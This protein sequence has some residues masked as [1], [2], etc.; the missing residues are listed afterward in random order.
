MDPTQGMSLE[1]TAR[2]RKQAEAVNSRL[3][4]KDGSLKGDMGRDAFL[5]LLVTELRH[6]DPT[7]PMQDREFISQMAQFSSLEQ[8]TNI[9]SSMQSMYRSSRASEAYALLGKR[10]EAFNTATGR[11]VEGVVSKVF[12]KDNEVRVIVDGQEVGLGD[13]HAVLPPLEKKPPAADERIQMMLKPGNHPAGRGAEDVR[14]NEL[15][16]NGINNDINRDAAKKSYGVN[17]KQGPDPR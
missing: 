12:F 11:A 15:K 1:E 4:R 10:V 9:N 13:I 17:V 14:N 3:K 5:K 2:A 6:Q 16:E 7:Q 8:M